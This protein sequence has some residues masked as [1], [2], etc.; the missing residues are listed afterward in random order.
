MFVPRIFIIPALSL[1][2]AHVISKSDGPC[3]VHPVFR[4]VTCF[5]NPPKIPKIEEMHSK[6][7]S[8]RV[9]KRQTGGRVSTGGCGNDRISQIMEHVLAPLVTQPRMKLGDIAKILQQSVQRATGLSYEIMMGKGDMVTTSHQM[10]E[11][12]HCRMRVGEF[13]T[14]MHETPVQYDINNAELEQEL[15]N[16]DFGEPLGGSG[17]PGQKPWP[18]FDEITSNQ[19]NTSNPSDGEPDRQPGR[20]PARIGRARLG[21]CGHSELG[22]LMQNVLGP[23]LPGTRLRLGDVALRLQQ[24]VQRSTGRSY[25][26][27]MG[28]GNSMISMSS[29]LPGDTTHCRMRVGEYYTVMYE[30]PVQ[31]DITDVALEQYLSHI[32]VGEPLGSTALLGQEVFGQLVQVQVPQVA[33]PMFFQAQPPVF[34]PPVLQAQLPVF[35]AQ[36]PIFQAQPPVFQAQPP[37]LQAQAQPPVF[38]AQAQPPVLQAQAQFVQPPPVQPAA[39]QAAYAPPFVPPVV[40]L[41]CFS[42][43]TIVETT[44]GH[45]RMSD[46]KTG[47]EVMSVEES[48]L[49]FSP[50]IMFLHREEEILAEFNVITTTNG[51]SVKLTNEH[52]I[53]VSDCVPTSP[54]Q[55]IS[56]KEVTTEHCLMAARTDDRT[57][58]TDR[59]INVTKTYERGIYAPLTSSGDIIVNDVLSSCHSNLAV[60]TLQQ[61]IFSLYRLF[62]RCL[63]FLLPEEG[64][65]PFGVESFTKAVDLFIPCKAVLF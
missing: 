62:H 36:P 17:Y 63:S 22:Q 46:L 23:F 21:G 37:V 51:N 56:S 41:E 1:L 52:L 40:P 65:L 55:L 39:F 12:S 32:D 25:E 5:S 54:L 45:K 48:L 30:T 47:D 9:F 53:Y 24:A 28:K 43:D 4:N 31:Y 20:D 15:S 13:Y 44:E 16:I 57:L 33:Q 58:R 2:V 29:Y 14:T 26:I 6:V 50:I 38:Q 64:A 11:T 49:T 10:S 35:Q 59:V 3:V 18:H 61:S 7:E 19:G 8:K 34:Q 42:A 27:I 60:K